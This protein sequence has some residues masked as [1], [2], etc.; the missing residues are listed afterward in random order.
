[1]YGNKVLNKLKNNNFAAHQTIAK[2]LRTA[3]RYGMQLVIDEMWR[4]ER[5]D[6][7]WKSLFI[8]P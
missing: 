8:F 5:S 7:Y 2:L 3:V 4:H 1:M 6:E